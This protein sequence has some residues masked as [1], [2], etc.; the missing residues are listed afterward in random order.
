MRL[1]LLAVASA[2]LATSGAEAN[3]IANGNFE[4]GLTDWTGA[5][6]GAFGNKFYANPN[7]APSPVSL[8]PI[9]F[10]PSGGTTVAVSDQT[11]PGGEALFQSFTTNGG[12]LHLTFDWFDNTYFTQFGTA[13]DGT[14]QVG[15]VDI[16]S[17]IDP[18]G[19]GPDVVE[20][21]ILNPSLPSNP[22][23]PMAVPWEFASFQFTL[24]PGTYE[25]RFGNGQCCNFQEFGVDNVTLTT[26]EPLTSS[27]LCFGI[28]GLVGLRRRRKA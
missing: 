20:N 27:I 1:L 16:M 24:A 26:P 7:G 8:R 15:R 22:D 10:L 13:I 2:V 3:L 6:T 28:A 19:I 17:A 21:L 18:F 12:V 23:A 9:A 14:Q 11:G 4:A 25:L 5:T